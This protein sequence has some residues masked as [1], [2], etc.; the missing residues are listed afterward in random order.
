MT[1]DP[2]PKEDL[3]EETRKKVHRYLSDRLLLFK[4]DAAEQSA[5]LIS[6][7]MG[8]IVVGL[9]LF[10]VLFFV[11]LMLGY[12]FAAWTGNM[13][14]GFAILAG[15]YLLL[16]VVLVVAFKQWIRPKIINKVIS[17]F[18]EEKT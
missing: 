9:L 18:F 8:M 11:S 17:I 12:L 2:A 10:F 4:M 13:F 1:P 14:Y 6:L 5:K 3:L 7:L 15:L 16:L